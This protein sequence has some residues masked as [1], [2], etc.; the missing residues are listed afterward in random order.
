MA[1]AIVYFLIYSYTQNLRFVSLIIFSFFLAFT[2]SPIFLF[3]A[4]NI[5]YV[6]EVKPFDLSIERFS[7]GQKIVDVY[8]N[9][10]NVATNFWLGAGE[11][12]VK[13]LNFLDNYYS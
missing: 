11:L 8:W 3:T 5:S 4:E 10:R 12:G 1:Y 6:A 7:F 9:S 2:R 13:S